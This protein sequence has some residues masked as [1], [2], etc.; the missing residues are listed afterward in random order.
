ML[1][2]QASRGRQRDRPGV[3]WGQA[4]T[5]AGTATFVGVA[6]QGDPIEIVSP[7]ITE[8]SKPPPTT[9]IGAPAR[10][11]RLTRL[12]PVSATYRSPLQP[13]NVAAAGLANI[14]PTRQRA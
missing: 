2:T 1:F 9:V 4:N 12:F 10:L 3:T 13:Q 14:A 5:T 11:K 6:A 8:I 7:G